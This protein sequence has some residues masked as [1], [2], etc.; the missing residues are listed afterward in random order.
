M[1]HELA[2]LVLWFIAIVATML[3]VREKT[4]FTYLGPLYAICTIGS[5]LIVRQARA[6]DGESKN[7]HE[8]VT[9]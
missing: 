4:L 2:T 9:N 6:R 5:L 3:L 8:K 7:R 1:K